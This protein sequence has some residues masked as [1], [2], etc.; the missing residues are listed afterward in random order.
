MRM[1]ELSRVSGV[2]VATIKYY[3]REGL[4]PAGHLTPPNQ[5]SYD[6]S[7]V[8]RLTLIR[9]LTDVGG[10]SIATTRAVL[11]VIDDPDRTVRQKL[12]ATIG[13]LG[14]LQA[15]A[16]AD[17]TDRADRTGEEHVQAAKTVDDLLERRGWRIER[18][19]PAR[20]AAA[21]VL[22]RLDRLGQH[23]AI[24]AL[25]RY[26]EA[27]EVAAETDLDVVTGIEDEDELVETALVGTVLGDA[28]LA[29]LRRLAQEHVSGNRYRTPPR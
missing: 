10:M 4:L 21:D 23:R 24:A 14:D 9:A 12:G 18:T 1:A 25:D 6:Q 2:P 15:G 8:R 20:T 17:K 27:A 3:L 5:A 26:A 13:S 22:T 19:S 28:L 29:A 16:G 11:S 7:H